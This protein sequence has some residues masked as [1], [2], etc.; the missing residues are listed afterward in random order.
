[1][2]AASLDVLCDFVIKAW[3]KV[4]ETEIKSFKKCGISNAMDGTEDYLLW[5]TDDAADAPDLDWDPYDD[6]VNNE[7]QDVY[8][9]LFA[10]DD[11]SE[12]DGL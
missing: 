8:D 11:S 9:E 7:T 6:N 12:F 5:D 10:S 4:R 2:R 1:M 3:D